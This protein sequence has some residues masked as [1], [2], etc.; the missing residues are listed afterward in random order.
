[1][2]IKRIV[3]P[4]IH[5]MSSK[6]IIESAQLSLENELS[7]SVSTQFAFTNLI[8]LAFRLV[9]TIGLNSSNSS[10][11]PS[12]DPN[13]PR[14]FTTRGKGS[15]RKPGGQIG[16]DG[17]CLNQIEKP[18]H[19]NTILMDT[20][21]LPQ[22]FYEHV[23]FEKRQVFDVN[24]SVVVTEYK[25]EI[26]QDQNGVQF[27]AEFPAG[28]TE[29][30]QYGNSV[31]VTSVYF[32]QSQL[33][34]LDRVRECFHDQ[35]GLA[36]AKGTISNFNL[37]AYK[38]LETFE[39]WAKKSLIDSYCNNVDETGI[40]INGKNHWLHCL[41]NPELTLFFPDPKRGSEAMERM[42]VLPNFHGILVHDHWKP[43][44]SYD[45]C[46][47]ALCNAHHLRELE[48]A[49]EQDG[50]KWAKQMQNL[51]LDMKIATDNE[52]GALAEKEVIKFKAKYHRLL[53][54]A[55]KEC[56]LESKSRAQ[57]KSRNLLIRLKKF[58]NETLLFMEDP[59]VPFTNNQAENDQRMTK[60]QQ[61][62][63][64]CFRTLEGAKIFC[65]IRSY[66]ITCQKN[67]LR[68][69]EALK[70]LFDGKLPSFMT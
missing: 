50:Q 47:H 39:E 53:E 70:I 31:K 45:Q 58:A 19:I 69:T 28:V 25:A 7:I 4:G 37:A 9:N 27:L 16:H 51:L 21:T 49:F 11:P 3:V 66:I 13:R 6:E 20:Q 18:D 32:S 12:K 59:L 60:V 38:K 41:S 17:S 40:N 57:S 14:D 63:S 48:R 61:K 67:G 29:P 62:I 26:V 43:Y 22:G 2:K 23:G 46:L 30:A 10:T 33:I 24:V 5:P 68:A 65:R 52:G 8:D 56:P 54:K 44:L 1:M 64:G 34:P 42:G 36:I 35:F 55:E 15:I